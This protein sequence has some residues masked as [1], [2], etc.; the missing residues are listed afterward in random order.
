MRFQKRLLGRMQVGA[1]KRRST[2]HAAHREHLQFHPLAS[3]VRI[4]FVPIDLRLPAPAITLRYADLVHGHPQH[5]LSIVH[6]L[7]NRPFSDPALR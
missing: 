7:A 6:I 4:S 3:Q 5:D 1:V 2:G